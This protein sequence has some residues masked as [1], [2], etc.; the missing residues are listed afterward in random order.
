MGHVPM[1]WL[2]KEVG[3]RSALRPSVVS[4]LWK[5][6]GSAVG[7]E[8]GSDRPGGEVADSGDADAPVA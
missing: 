5:V 8:S 4:A 7:R 1:H 2:W 6:L 3:F